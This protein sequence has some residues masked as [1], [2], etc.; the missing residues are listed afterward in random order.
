MEP[1]PPRTVDRLNRC[2]GGPQRWATPE[3]IPINTSKDV[4]MS[5]QARGPSRC[6]GGTQPMCWQVNSM[7]NER[8]E[9]TIPPPFTPPP[10]PPLSHKLKGINRKFN[11]PGNIKYWRKYTVSVSVMTP[12]ICK[13]V[14][15]V[16]NRWNVFFKHWSE[17]FEQ[18]IKTRG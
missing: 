12:T 6:L 11:N 1:H 16:K 10:L 9:E 5:N 3:I 8:N 14:Q 18:H 7:R 2:Q 15:S 4:D 13:M 17:S